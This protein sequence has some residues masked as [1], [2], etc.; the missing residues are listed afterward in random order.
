MTWGKRVLGVVCV[1]AL[2]CAFWTTPAHA[3]RFPR[4]AAAEA[5]LRIATALD[6]AV[7]PFTP[8]VPAIIGYGAQAAMEK[9]IALAF[10]ALGAY[11]FSQKHLQLSKRAA[12]IDDDLAAAASADVE[13]GEIALTTG[14][15]AEAENVS[16]DLAHL[17]ER[18]QLPWAEASAKEYLGVLDRRHGNLDSA[19]A[20]EQRALDLQREL[21]DQHGIGTALSNLGTIARD[22]GDFAR[23]LDLNLQALD[24]REHSND[25]LELTLRNLALIYRELGDDEATRRYFGRALDVAAQHGDIS[26]YVAT[27]GTFASYQVDM[28][29]FDAALAAADE[30]LAIARVIGNRP[31][32]AFELLD[33]GRALLGL[34]K[35]PEATARLEE[36]LSLGHELQQHEIVARSQVAL[37]EAALDRG[38]RQ[39]AHA[40]L[41]DTYADPQAHQY[42]PLLIQAFALSE[43]LA[44][45]NGDIA[46]ALDFAHQQGAMREDLVGTRA[47]RR[48]SALETQNARA[49]SEHQLALVTKDNQL[50]TERLAQQRL[51]RNVGIAALI[52]AAILIGLLA[53]RFFGVRRLNRAL[54]VRNVEIES[55]RAAL[56]DANTRLEHQAGELFQAAIT[57]PLTGVLNRGYVLRQ[58]DIRI[59]DCVRDGRDLAVLLIDFDNFKQINDTR[60][61]VFGDRVL[62]AGVQTMRQWLEPGDLLGRYG[63]EEFII[64]A[65]DRDTTEITIFAERLR[66][67]VAETLTMFAPELERVATISIG[68][69]RLAQL[70]PPV[71]LEMLIEAADKAV[72]AAKAHG[73]NRVMHHSD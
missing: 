21:G 20:L 63:G 49:I 39:R 69:A 22:R 4:A 38:D 13:M 55:Q 53:W 10:R 70:P 45:A 47:S 60:G 33:S 36:A 50:Q 59:A 17:A 31:A 1:G 57:D 3:Q 51:Q 25:Q 65:T 19:E 28:R 6:E 62:I 61:H 12:L 58:L 44:M 64:V 37:A 68:I 7:D 73:R 34:G 30:S 5:Q 23:A 67:R 24:V 40:L 41:E 16:R 2:C 66:V 43:K 27:L 42:K 71:R 9:T 35:V 52:G 29:E 46:S 32:I 26:N 72:Y 15:Y 8:A 56:S 18:A 14:N 11:A 54:A 48:L